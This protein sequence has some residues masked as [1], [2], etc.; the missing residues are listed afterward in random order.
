MWTSRPSLLTSTTT[1]D[2]SLVTLYQRGL[3]INACRKMTSPSYCLTQLIIFP[4]LKNAKHA[5]DNA[6]LDSECGCY[7]CKHY[8]RAYLHHVTRAKEIIGSMLLTY[9]NLYY[10]QQLMSEIRE[11]IAQ[12]AFSDFVA[13]FE[14][15]LSVT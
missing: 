15:G 1:Y 12:G 11:A 13:D 4:Y 9:H 6:P 5:D 2:E 3:D 10:Y 7:T 14:A 8:S